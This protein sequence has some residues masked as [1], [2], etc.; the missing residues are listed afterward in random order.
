MLALT[1]A[2]TNSVPM[3]PIV[4]II[5]GILGRHHDHGCDQQQQPPTTKT[6]TITLNKN[7]NW[8]RNEKRKMSNRFTSIVRLCKHKDRRT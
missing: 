8:N 2:I 1:L 4:S 5:S 7:K 6:R 3:I